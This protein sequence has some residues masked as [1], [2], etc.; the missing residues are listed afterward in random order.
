MQAAEY[1]V[2][3][4]LGNNDAREIARAMKDVERRRG[5]PDREKF[6]SSPGDSVAY[7]LYRSAIQVHSCEP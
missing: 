7:A 1:L 5:G 3:R 4:G 6:T 2:R